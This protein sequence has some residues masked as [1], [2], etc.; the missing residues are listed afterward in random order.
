[1]HSDDELRILNN[2]ISSMPKVYRK[3]N[4]N[5][6]VVHDILLMGTSMAGRTSCIIKCG[7]LGI[8][9]Y[10]HELKVEVYK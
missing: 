8:N 7:E 3:R 2:Y 6:T 4:D 1:M 9:P 10:S 5:A